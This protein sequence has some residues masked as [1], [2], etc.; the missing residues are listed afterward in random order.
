MQIELSLFES[1]KT[2]VTIH[3]A[4]WHKYTTDVFREDVFSVLVW[5]KTGGFYRKISYTQ[6]NH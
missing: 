5:Q 3:T 4:Q 6:M 2:W 1:E